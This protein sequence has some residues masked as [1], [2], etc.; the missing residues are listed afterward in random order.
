[1]SHG[2]SPSAASAASITGTGTLYM[3]AHRHC[4]SMRRGGTAIVR[5]RCC[6]A[7]YTGQVW[8][9]AVAAPALAGA[10]VTDA[11]FAAIADTAASTGDIASNG[12][13]AE[14][15]QASGGCGAVASASANGRGVVAVEHAAATGFA[16][17]TAATAGQSSLLREA[18]SGSESESALDELVQSSHRYS[19]RPFIQDGT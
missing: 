12:G 9:A 10:T 7:S 18:N 17:E 1:M 19:K 14:A 2:T 4:S 16:N 15:Y 5:R 13:R 11:S 3:G 6:T 8:A